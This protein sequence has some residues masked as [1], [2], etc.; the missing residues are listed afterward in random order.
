MRVYR[1]VL[2]VVAWAALVWQYGLMVEGQPAAEIA[3]RTVNF[4]S[5]FTILTNLLCALAL[6]LP[7]IAPDGVGRFWVRPV[8]RGMITVCIAIVMIVYHLLL[9]TT[10][11]PQGAQK[12]VDY[13]LHYIVPAA[14]V[15]DWLLF[16]PKGAL[17]WSAAFV[18]LA[19]PLVYGLWTLAH[20]AMSGFYPYPF[21]DVDALGYPA[22]LVNMAGLV[23]AFLLPG[24]ILV[25]LDRLMGRIARKTA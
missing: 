11:D 23:F 7:L 10:W 8:V 4:F 19:Y 9:R 18:W 24:L 25:G 2:A 17:R 1:A 13:T 16:V 6:T 21:M 22:V 5:F 3:A 12:V 20:G 14:F 15:L